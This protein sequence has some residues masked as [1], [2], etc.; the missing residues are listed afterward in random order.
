MKGCVRKEFVAI[1]NK[2]PKVTTAID[3]AKG[4]KRH[5]GVLDFLYDI[6]HE[7]AS[8]A[9]LLKYKTDHDRI[10]NRLQAAV[11]S[12]L[13]TNTSVLV[14]DRHCRHAGVH[15]LLQEGYTNVYTIS[16]AD[17]QSRSV[18][19]ERGTKTLV[20]Q[21]AKATKDV[22]VDTTDETVK[23]Q[24]C[25]HFVLQSSFDTGQQ[26]QAEESITVS[27]KNDGHLW[28]F[29]TCLFD[30][31]AIFQGFQSRSKKNPFFFRHLYRTLDDLC[32][33]TFR[34][35]QKSRDCTEKP[36][37]MCLT[38][39]KQWRKNE[40]LAH[41][42][43]K[44]AVHSLLVTETQS[45]GPEMYMYC[46]YKRPRQSNGAR[47]IAT[48]A[49]SNGATSARDAALEL[50]LE[51]EKRLKERQLELERRKRLTSLDS[52]DRRVKAACDQEQADAKVRETRA[53]PKRVYVQVEGTVTRI[54][55]F[56]TG[57]AFLSLEFDKI[58]EDRPL[59]VFFQSDTMNLSVSALLNLASLLR[60]G[61]QL[62][63]IGFMARN[64][65]GHSMLQVEAMA[66]TRTRKYE[67]FS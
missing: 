23:L 62:T 54:R 59:Q 51:Q 1:E 5:E 53:E 29:V 57:L 4:R 25:G 10:R 39:R 58:G 9:A 40:F 50:W 32:S 22:K 60:K 15:F 11:A 42:E 12:H 61:D 27:F 43:L 44:Y 36:S 49:K 67:A 19:S 24:P 37:L 47:A 7:S 46:C 64:A 30:M 17:K 3:L 31:G 45:T 21:L 38:P 65:H 28:P 14:L 20:L 18:E 13:D 66:L 26:I 8:D 33:T 35:A 63:A 16:S 55:R 48:V 41:S 56:S 2:G 34:D 52:L 6:Q